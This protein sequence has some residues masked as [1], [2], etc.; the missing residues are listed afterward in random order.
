MSRW[1][2]AALCALA[3]LAG[4]IAFAPAR[5]AYDVWLRPNGVTAYAV[6]GTVWRAGLHEAT[7]R[8]RRVASVRTETRL[9]PLLAGR[10]ETRFEIADPELR[11]TGHA[12]ASRSDWALGEASGMA[13]L[14]RDAGLPAAL[15][16][17]PLRVEGLAVQ[18]SQTGCETA[19]GRARTGALAAAGERHGVALPMLEG[20][21]EC[22]GRDVILRLS[23]RSELVGVEGWARIGAR[24]IDWSFEAVPA[25]PDVAALLP[26]LGFSEQEGAWRISGTGRA[27]G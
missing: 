26:A 13:R 11:L 12:S 8:G 9:L 17:Q 20:G 1:I 27:A 7:V 4:L 10:A 22:E 15:A 16:G 2:L 3:L 21:F 5:M 18:F 23:G 6:E 25:G 19:S 14:P 24:G